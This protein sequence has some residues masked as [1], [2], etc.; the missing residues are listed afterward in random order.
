M[1]IVVLGKSGQVATSLRNLNDN[2]T[3]IIALGRDSLDLSI[4]PDV[5]SQI[6]E[7]EPDALIN[8]A[9]Y[10]AV[11]QAE[12]EPERARALNHF[13]VEKLAMVA[14]Q[15]DIPIVHISTDYVFDGS[16]HAPWKPKDQTGPLGVYGQSKLAGETALTERAARYAI[17]RTSWVFSAHG[18]N[19]VKTMLRLGKE[20]E[21]VSIV[22]DQFGGPTCADDIASASVQI[23]KVLRTDPKLKGI[24]HYSGQQDCNWADFAKE[25]FLQAEID[26]QVHSIASSEYPT[27]ATRP[28]N[29]RLDCSTTERD[30]G[31]KRPFWKDSLNA[32]LAELG[33]VS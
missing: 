13:A 8:A 11:D 3:T 20:R 32:V 12:S 6:A 21:S 30:F 10:T 29:S 15:L 16:G 28:L 25:I 1:K 18:A 7:L 14:Q 17:L 22:G 4:A 26:C 9:A 2:D 23:A 27:A 24:W 5:Q 19:F 31:I 33:D